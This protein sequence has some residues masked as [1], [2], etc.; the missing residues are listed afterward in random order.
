MAALSA[1]VVPARESC[2]LVTT[3]SAITAINV[4]ARNR[5]TIIVVLPSLKVYI[6]EF[7]KR[8]AHERNSL[9]FGKS[10]TFGMTEHFIPKK[11]RGGW[12]PKSCVK[13][14]RSRAY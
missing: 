7:S 10:R 4:Q 3:G 6:S 1:G 14:I 13:V 2:P 8:D 9:R 5:S 12:T 11:E